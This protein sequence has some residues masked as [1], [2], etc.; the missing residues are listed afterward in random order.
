MRLT[1]FISSEIRY[2]NQRVWEL[3]LENWKLEKEN[4]KLKEFK[5]KLEENKFYIKALME[6]SKPETA[7]DAEVLQKAKRIYEELYMNELRCLKKENEDLKLK[8]KKLEK[9]VKVNP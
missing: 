5:Y 8:I 6:L 1:E 2:L 9:R 3:M 7:R 4:I